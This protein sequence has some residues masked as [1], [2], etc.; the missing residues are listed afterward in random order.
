MDNLNQ[1]NSSKEDA[2][3]LV[4][5][6]VLR[7]AT[8]VL[9]LISFYLAISQIGYFILAHVIR[10]ERSR[11]HDHA[12]PLNILCTCAGVMVCLRVGLPLNQLVKIYVDWQCVAIME[13]RII[14]FGIAF[15]LLYTILWIRQRAF[16]WCPA[17]HDLSTRP[18]KIFSMATPFII[19]PGCI[20]SIVIVNFSERYY[21]TEYGCAIERTSLNTFGWVFR[22]VAFSL[23]QCNLLALFLY[24][25]HRHRI[26]VKRAALTQRTDSIDGLITRSIITTII[27]IVMDTASMLIGLLLQRELAIV[28]H[29]VYDVNLVVDTLAVFWSFSNYAER[30]FPWKKLNR[31]KHVI[32]TGSVQNS[33]VATVIW[34]SKPQHW[35]RPMRRNLIAPIQY[36]HSLVKI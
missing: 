11:N 26:M 8:I 30:L 24:P 33:T 10:Q 19:W 17:L 18:V 13:Y 21:T 23:M 6:D 35:L 15:S 28:P 25:L 12:R 31:R 3:I 32:E 22:G 16:Y 2:Y 27:C 4:E 20:A 5:R 9:A 36:R 14:T 34:L 1:L 7:S 29:F